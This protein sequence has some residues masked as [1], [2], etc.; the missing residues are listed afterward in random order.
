MSFRYLS[1][2]DMP[3]WEP[4]D[5]RLTGSPLDGIMSEHELLAF[6]DQNTPDRPQQRLDASACRNQMAEKTKNYQDFYRQFDMKRFTGKK[7]LEVGCGSGVDAMLWAESGA[8][9]HCLDR[10]LTNVKHTWAGLE[11][12]GHTG[13]FMNASASAIPFSDAVFDVCYSHGVLH[14]TCKGQIALDEIR[15]VLKPGGTFIGMIYHKNSVNYWRIVYRWGVLG[16]ELYRGYTED[17]IVARYCEG[18][19]DCGYAQCLTVNQAEEFLHR[20][21]SVSVIP[22]Y[23]GY[24]DFPEET[25]RDLPSPRDIERIEYAP[26]RSFFREAVQWKTREEFDRKGGWFLYL[27]AV[28]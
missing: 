17:R 24:Y 15:R 12:L 8:Q 26:A 10:S 14:H 1:S 20:F 25:N 27:N 28:K 3:Y 13:V 7:L 23:S 21:R 6:W 16:K 2:K 22:C 5:S 4:D 9:Y 18:G 11:A 19:G